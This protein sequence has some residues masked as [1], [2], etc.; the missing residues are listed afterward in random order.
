MKKLILITL[1]GLIVPAAAQAGLIPGKTCRGFHYRGVAVTEVTTRGDVAC[2]MAATLAKRYYDAANPGNPKQRS[3]SGFQIPGFPR[4]RGYWY[5]GTPF[6]LIRPL[7]DPRKIVGVHG[8]FFLPSRSKPEA[9]AAAVRFPTGPSKCD[10]AALPPETKPFCLVLH[11]GQSYRTPPY[12][13]DH[14]IWLWLSFTDHVDVD[15]VFHSIYLNSHHVTL[16]DPYLDDS[17]HRLGEWRAIDDLW[18]KHSA[19]PVKYGIV[20]YPAP[21]E[22]SIIKAYKTIYLTVPSDWKPLRPILKR[23]PPRP[24]RSARVAA[25]AGSARSDM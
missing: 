6:P 20:K 22:R 25:A 2:K 10:K 21:G 7:N 12:G 4:W 8:P 23:P 1:L 16:E 9:V 19:H 17:N 13:Y 11:P 3:P 24:Q 5:G 18:G 15:G 14:N